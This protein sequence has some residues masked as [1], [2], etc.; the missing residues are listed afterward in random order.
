MAENARRR[1][2][3]KPSFFELRRPICGDR[4]GGS[5]NGLYFWN[6]GVEGYAGIYTHTHEGLGDFGKRDILGI[7]DF[8]N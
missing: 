8:R 3:R 6:Q 7:I 5:R 2:R 4:S 1:V